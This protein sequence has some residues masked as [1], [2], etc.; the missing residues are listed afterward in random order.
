MITRKGCARNFY[1]EASVATIQEYVHD[2]TPP[3]LENPRGGVAPHAGWFFSGRTA[4]R[5]FAALAAHAPDTATI[6][7]LGAVHRC[8]YESPRVDAADAWDTPL[9]PVGVDAELI[10]ELRDARIGIVEEAQAHTGEHSIEVS[11]PFV[12]HF[13]PGARV[14]PIA[15]PPF[16]DAATFGETL[17]TLLGTRPALVVASTD[18]TH[19]GE[20]YGFAPAGSEPERALRFVRENDE[21]M[22]ALVRALRADA[23]L[24]EA[25]TNQNSCGSGALC[26]AVAAAKARG[27]RSGVLIEYRTSY[28]SLPE[29]PAA[30]IVGYGGLVLA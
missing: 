3:A 12:K 16:A 9:G 18:L 5:V 13:F 6:V 25:R 20:D 7:F 4:A 2:F 24:A 10:G 8:A 19:Y 21:R 23:I 14:V 29:R 22:L 28:D 11:M 26:A 30:R 15:C 17:G 27:A 1:P